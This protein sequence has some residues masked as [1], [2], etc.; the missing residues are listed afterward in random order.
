MNK[1][2]SMREFVLERYDKVFYGRANGK[3]AQNYIAQTNNYAKFLSAINALGM[4]IPCDLDGNVLEEPIHLYSDNPDK[5][6]SPMYQNSIA[7]KIYNEAK[8]RVLFDDVSVRDIGSS[9][10]I[11]FNGS[12]L[13]RYSKNRKKLEN[14]EPKTIECLVKYG[15]TLT[16]SA[17]KQIIN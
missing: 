3:N 10:M 17:T 9:Y 2:I 7:V 16:E 13:F 14:N 4:F 5:E 6:N 11:V 8:S 12:N 15:L 1:L